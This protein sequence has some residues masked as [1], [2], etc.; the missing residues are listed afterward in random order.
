MGSVMDAGLCMQ[1]C[2]RGGQA[3]LVQLCILAL[4]LRCDRQRGGEAPP[5]P[6]HACLP[7]PVADTRRRTFFCSCA[8]DSASPGTG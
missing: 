5:P 3:A 2:S 8:T 6:L 4:R 7:H 1:W